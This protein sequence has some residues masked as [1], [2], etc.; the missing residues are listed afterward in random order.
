MTT[1]QKVILLEWLAKQRLPVDSMLGCRV[2]GCDWH[3]V[4]YYF[5]ELVQKGLVI[6]VGIGNSGLTLYQ[7]NREA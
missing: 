1:E 4:G 6:R 7:L 3:E 5:E 2:V